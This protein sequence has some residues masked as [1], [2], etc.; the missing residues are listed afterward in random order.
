MVSFL[1][2]LQLERQASPHTLRSY[3]DDLEVFCR[4]LEESHLEGTDPGLIDPHGFD[5]IRPG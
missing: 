3:H 1:D 5:V 2:H 4:F